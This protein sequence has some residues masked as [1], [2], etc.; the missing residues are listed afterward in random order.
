M[1]GYSRLACLDLAGSGAGGGEMGG[2]TGLSAKKPIIFSGGS[3][4]GGAWSAT[5][6]TATNRGLGALDGC[7][8][9]SFSSPPGCLTGVAVKRGNVRHLAEPPGIDDTP[10]SM[11][12]RAGLMFF[13]SQGLTS[14]LMLFASKS[15]CAT[16][17]GLSA[18]SCL[19]L[20]L[21][22]PNWKSC[23]VLNFGSTFGVILPTE[24]VGWSMA[25]SGL[26]S[27]GAEC[28]G[29]STALVGISVL[30]A[31]LPAPTCCSVELE[32]RPR[33][34]RGD[35][36]LLLSALVAST[37]CEAQ[38]SASR[39]DLPAASAL[40]AAAGSLDSSGCG[41]ATD[42]CG[43]SSTEDPCLLLEA[44]SRFSAWS[45]GMSWF[46]FTDAVSLSTEIS[47][48]CGSACSRKRVWFD[49][50]DAVSLSPEP[51][52]CGGCSPSAPMPGSLPGASASCMRGSDTFSP[53]TRALSWN[54]STSWPAAGSA[55]ESRARAPAC[56]P[57]RS[58][59]SQAVTEMRRGGCPGAAARPVSWPPSR[60][61]C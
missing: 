3:Y 50:T 12:L 49:L 28:C 51:S 11:L 29:A 27:R 14:D 22:L 55:A 20:G 26:R 18:N 34:A 23:S 35:C 48:G 44:P 54:G 19:G 21:W 40:P 57:A 59:S 46:S 60:S 33:D 45:T 15:K 30:A 9:G 43:G 1:A 5:S 24:C 41:L 58:S 56:C 32:A 31:T 61:R 52:L 25:G 42:S 36:P 4:V 39:G 47:L 10:W 6:F 17:C 13:C 53:G 37:D 2:W 16:G 38:S 7:A 8:C